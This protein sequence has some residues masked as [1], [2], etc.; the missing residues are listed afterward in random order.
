[1]QFITW[2]EGGT[3]VH[4]IIELKYNMGAVEGIKKLKKF[5]MQFSYTFFALSIWLLLDFMTLR[6]IQLCLFVL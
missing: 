5:L 6:V 2:N 3:V 4:K 1:M